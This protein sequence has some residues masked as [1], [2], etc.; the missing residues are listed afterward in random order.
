MHGF[1]SGLCRWGWGWLD[2]DDDEDEE[3]SAAGELFHESEAGR[4][5]T[6]S[7]GAGAAAK[8]SGIGSSSGSGSGAVPSARPL[9]HGPSALRVAAAIEDDMFAPASAVVP[10]TVPLTAGPVPPPSKVRLPLS[11]CLLF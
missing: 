10:D 7:S 9:L 3:G 8:A 1:P 2:E 6:A 4:A 11:L 5:G